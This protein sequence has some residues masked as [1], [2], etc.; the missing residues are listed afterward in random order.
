VREAVTELVGLPLE[1][2]HCGT[3]WRFRGSITQLC[4]KLGQESETTVCRYTCDECAATLEMTVTEPNT[5]ST[6]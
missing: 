3:P 6:T 1:H 4:G 2:A 5:A